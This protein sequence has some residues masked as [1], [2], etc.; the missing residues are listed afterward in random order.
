MRHVFSVSITCQKNFAEA[1][2]KL[3]D[4]MGFGPNNL[5]PIDKQGNQFGCTIEWP[6]DGLA[7]LQRLADEHPR[8]DIAIAPRTKVPGVVR[9]A[10]ARCKLRF[11]RPEYKSDAPGRTKAKVMIGDESVTGEFGRRELL[12]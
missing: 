8:L 6:R 4:A 12:G 11:E 10:M 2:N 1:V 9:S 5:H 7:E 3:L